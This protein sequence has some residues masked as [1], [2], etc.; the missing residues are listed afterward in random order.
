MTH[1]IAGLQAMGMVRAGDPA[2]I[3]AT[4]WA[5]LHGLVM[6]SLDGQTVGV[7]PSTTALVDELTAVLMFG[8]APRP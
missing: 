5:S 3:A 4:T 2:L 7:A 8:M 1:G 6:L